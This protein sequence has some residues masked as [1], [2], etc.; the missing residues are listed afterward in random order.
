MW[1]VAS[2]MDSQ[3]KL[4]DLVKLTWRLALAYPA[5]CDFL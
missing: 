4:V 1:M 5:L 3:P 2:Y